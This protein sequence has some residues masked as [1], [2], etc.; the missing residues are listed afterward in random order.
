MSL[1]NRGQVPQ[2]E[3]QEPKAPDLKP[4]TLALVREQLSTNPNVV[5]VSERTSG[6]QTE[7]MLEFINVRVAPVNPIKEPEAL[8]VFMDGLFLGVDPKHFQRTHGQL[9]FPESS[10]DN[11]FSYILP[12]LVF[13]E[14]LGTVKEQTVVR[15]SGVFFDREALERHGKVFEPEEQE[16]QKDTVIEYSRGV[17]VCVYPDKAIAELYVRYE[18]QRKTGVNIFPPGT[19]ADLEHLWNSITPQLYRRWQAGQ[20]LAGFYFTPEG[21]FIPRFYRVPAD[22]MEQVKKGTSPGASLRLGNFTEA[23]QITDGTEV[24]AR[25]MLWRTYRNLT[26]EHLAEKTYPRV[27]VH[28]IR[29]IENGRLNPDQNTLDAVAHG[30]GVM[31]SELNAVQVFPEGHTPYPKSRGR[32]NKI[33][34][35]VYQGDIKEAATSEVE[36]ISQQEAFGAFLRQKRKE[37]GLS[38]AKLGNAAGGIPQPIISG[39]ERGNKPLDIKKVSQIATALGLS[40]EE[41]QKFIDLYKKRKT[42]TSKQIDH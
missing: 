7:R 24:G 9:N 21:M 29:S 6:W 1:E 25:V 23:F 22:K 19:Q 39:L 28:T 37:V 35:V 36:T 2:P 26:Q 27:S 11:T 15:R 31:S 12:E 40:E 18:E 5:V 42:K 32:E 8:T 20:D 4:P 17:E 33:A 41:T 14:T 10:G 16:E 3:P 30:I 38:Q 34:Q 13:F